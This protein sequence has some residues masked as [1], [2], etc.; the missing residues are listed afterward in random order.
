MGQDLPAYDQVLPQGLLFLSGQSTVHTDFNPLIARPVTDTALSEPAYE[1]E[2]WFP[3]KPFAINQLGDSARLVVVP[4]R[5]TGDEQSGTEEVFQR[6]TFRVYYAPEDT[7][8]TAGPSIWEITGQVSASGDSAAV[9]ALVQDSSGVGRV[10]ATY[11]TTQDDGSARWQSTDLT[12][13]EESGYWEG[14]VSASAGRVS[15]FIQAV[16]RAGNTSMSAN[17]GVFFAAEEQK[18]YLPLV[19]RG[20]SV[21]R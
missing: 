6:M 16:D 10:V 18:V 13:N 14:T 3:A 20:G 4:A 5:Y 1:Y 15:Y 9:R 21:G 7:E 19:M 17:K 12:Y 2:G 8:D 11:R